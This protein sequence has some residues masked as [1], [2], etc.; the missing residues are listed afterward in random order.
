MNEIFI[1][2]L[3]VQLP[4]WT[5]VFHLQLSTCQGKNNPTANYPVQEQKTGTRSGNT[6]SQKAGGRREREERQ[7][8]HYWTDWRQDWCVGASPDWRYCT[9]VAWP[10]LACRWLGRSEGTV[11]LS[12]EI[13]DQ[14]FILHRDLR[15]GAALDRL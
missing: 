12:S 2:M 5:Y 11:Q 3:D 4:D 10:G 1:E 8:D 7:R 6:D 9:T 14:F 13:S 15:P